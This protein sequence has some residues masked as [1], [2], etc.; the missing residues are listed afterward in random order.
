MTMRPHFN[1][2]Q[3]EVGFDPDSTVD[4]WWIELRLGDWSTRSA[5]T[6]GYGI[7]GGLSNVERRKLKGAA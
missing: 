7:W 6:S 3:Y 2:A 5:T 4:S 1:A